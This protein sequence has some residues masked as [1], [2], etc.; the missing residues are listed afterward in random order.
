M[1][2]NRFDGPQNII[3]LL[4]GNRALIIIL[5]LYWILSLPQIY[6]KHFS[7]SDP[8]LYEQLYEIANM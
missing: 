2:D 1:K 4:L 6:G 7:L 3:G 5:Y 8:E